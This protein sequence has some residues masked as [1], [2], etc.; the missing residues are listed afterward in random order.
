MKPTQFK[1]GVD[2]YE[3]SVEVYFDPVDEEGS[4]DCDCRNFDWIVP[5]TP[6]GRVYW[7]CTE[8]EKPK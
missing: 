5:L 3:D 7:G 4:G 1:E 6:G 2:A 8:C